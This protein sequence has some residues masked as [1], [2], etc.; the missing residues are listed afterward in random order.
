MTRSPGRIPRL[1]RR[2]ALWGVALAAVAL[3]AGCKTPFSGEGKIET[4]SPQE[5]DR[6]F[7]ADD[8]Q[9]LDAE[10]TGWSDDP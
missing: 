1:A 7:M 6:D 9:K 2:A 3:P 10:G 4:G 5:G 8:F